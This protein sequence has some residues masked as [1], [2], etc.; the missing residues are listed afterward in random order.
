M[1]ELRSDIEVKH[2][3]YEGNSQTDRSKLDTLRP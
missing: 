3:H 2:S 1:G